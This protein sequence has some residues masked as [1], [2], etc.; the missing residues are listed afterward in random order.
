MNG[1]YGVLYRLF[2]SVHETI[3]SIHACNRGELKL[4]CMNRILWLK[5]NTVLTVQNTNFSPTVVQKNPNRWLICKLPVKSQQV[6]AQPELS[7]QR[8]AHREMN[9]SKNCQDEC[10]TN[11]LTLSAMKH[12]RVGRWLKLRSPFRYEP[13]TSQE[14]SHR[15]A[16]EIMDTFGFKYR[17]ILVWKC[18]VNSISFGRWNK[19]TF[20]RKASLDLKIV[21]PRWISSWQAP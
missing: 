13:W 16:H 15:R 8:Q 21:C 2:C 10:R 17:R 1:N 18:S 7:V 12:L 3:L 9:R 6:P 14:C 5:R 19:F 4:D 20:R 11:E